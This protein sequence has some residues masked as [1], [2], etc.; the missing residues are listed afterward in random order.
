M[1]DTSR[2][3]FVLLDGQ[4]HD[5]ASFSCGKASLDAYLKRRASQDV[6]KRAAVV[7]VMTTKDDP[8]TILGYYSLSASSVYSNDIPETIR[9]SLPRYDQVGVTLMGRLAIDQRFRGQG[10]GSILMMDALHRAVEAS[11]SIA[12]FAVLVDA[13]DDEAKAFYLHYGLIPF[14]TYPMRLF[15]PMKTIKALPLP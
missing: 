6:K 9:K 3:D 14:D 5:R 7:H 12:S 10:L 13:L 11:Q 1:A 4:T 8:A 15:L 2:Y